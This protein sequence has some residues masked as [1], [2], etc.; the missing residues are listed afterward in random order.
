[1]GNIYGTIKKK[2]F[3]ELLVSRTST[4]LVGYKIILNKIV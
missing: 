3:N 2:L 1:M 4:T